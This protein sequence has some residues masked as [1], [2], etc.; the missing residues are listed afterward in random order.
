[1]RWDRFSNIKSFFNIWHTNIDIQVPE[2]LP[3]QIL[4]III[5]ILLSQKTHTHTY[6]FGHHNSLPYK[7]NMLIFLSVELS[8]NCWFELYSPV[9]TVKVMLSQSVNRLK[10]ILE[11][12]V[13]S[14]D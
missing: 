13:L 3:A 4:Q 10:L 14:R 11:G 6:L 1:M 5:N 2:I 12:L 9:N 7:N 8:E